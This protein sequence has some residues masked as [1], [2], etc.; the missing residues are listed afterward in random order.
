MKLTKSFVPITLVLLTAT[1]SRALYSA[2]TLAVL[3]AEIHQQLVDIQEAVDRQSAG[4]A[5]H[6]QGISDPSEAYVQRWEKTVK[7]IQLKNPERYEAVRTKWYAL[8]VRTILSEIDPSSR[9]WDALDLAA[10]QRMERINSLY[11]GT[12]APDDRAQIALVNEISHLADWEDIQWDQMTASESRKLLTRLAQV[13]RSERTTPEQMRAFL[14]DVKVV[15]IFTSSANKRLDVLRSTLIQEANLKRVIAAIG[16]LVERRPEWVDIGGYQVVFINKYT[17]DFPDD[18]DPMPHVEGALEAAS[19]FENKSA[20]LTINL[21]DIN[22]STV[23]TVH[24]IATAPDFHFSARV[25]DEMIQRAEA[26]RVAIDP[27]R[28][29]DR[30]AIATFEQQTRQEAESR[31][32]KEE[33]KAFILGDLVNAILIEGFRMEQLDGKDIIDAFGQVDGRFKATIDP[34]PHRLKFRAVT[35]LTAPQS[36]VSRTCLLT[37]TATPKV[38]YALSKE[39]NNDEDLLLDTATGKSVGP[40]R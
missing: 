38:T 28:D 25:P 10:Q 7:P 9:S 26:Y 31:K 40:C 5:A 8:S 27:V 21:L 34:G 15:Q 1:A 11:A 23:T 22:G 36:T 16:S 14:D 13:Y 6:F 2:D 4:F 30:K 19:G 33:N 20:A 24:T 17:K 3:D 39:T 35:L 18:K 29:Q 37:F 12:K 32:L